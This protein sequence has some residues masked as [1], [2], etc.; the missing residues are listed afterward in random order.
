MSAISSIFAL[1]LGP[2]LASATMSLLLWLPFWIGVLV[3][4][5]AVVVVAMLPDFSPA[6]PTAP[7]QQDERQPLLLSSA[8]ASR[9]P[10]TLKKAISIQFSA[11]KIVLTSH[12]RNYGLLLASFVLTSLA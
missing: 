3:I 1:Q 8:L 4:L 2:A 7:R 12:P 6:Q 11:I 10:T 5:L 9:H